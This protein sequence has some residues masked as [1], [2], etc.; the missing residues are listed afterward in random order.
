MGTIQCTACGKAK[1]LKF[2]AIIE[3]DDPR[4]VHGA[5][6]F[7][8]QC[9]SCRDP[10]DQDIYEMS[11]LRLRAEIKKLRE[12]VRAHRDAEGH[13][14]CWYVPELWGLLPEKLDPKPKVPPVGEF[15]ENCAAYRA[16]LDNAIVQPIEWIP[17][18]GLCF[19]HAGP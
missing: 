3:S 12:G 7:E 9:N 16:T 18:K 10:L 8:E 4:W 11:T 5:F 1:A 15:L 6:Q 19:K 2:F 14:L 13:N 17:G